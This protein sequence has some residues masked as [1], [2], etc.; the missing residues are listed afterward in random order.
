MRI[1]SGGQSGADIGGLTAA[2]A[3][4]KQGHPIETGGVAPPAFITEHRPY[5]G[6]GNQAE[7]DR[8]V[9]VMKDA[10]VAAHPYWVKGGALDPREAQDIV[11]AIE[12]TRPG[13]RRNQHDPRTAINVRDADATA[14]FGGLKGGTLHTKQLAEHFGRPVIVD[15]TPEALVDFVREHG[16]Q[17]LNIAG[18]R[19]S[20]VPGNEQRT[21]QTVLRALELMEGGAPMPEQPAAVV[22]PTGQQA[23]DGVQLQLDLEGQQVQADPQR[24][25]G[26]LLPWLLAA[27]AGGLLGYG[28]SQSMD[29]GMA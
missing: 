21:H 22:N 3:W 11:E 13:A 10:G 5:N 28:V 24:K 25:A 6:R 16:V 1:I 2:L 19:E 23:A 26:D 15:P 9:Q 8:L 27:G 14:L 12:A 20:Q 4:K 7:H 29:D 18:R 17:T